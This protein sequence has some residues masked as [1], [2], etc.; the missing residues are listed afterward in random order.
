MR[1]KYKCSGCL[2]SFSG[3]TRSIEAGERV[4]CPS[5]VVAR[6]ADPPESKPTAFEVFL[7]KLLKIEES[8]CGC[9]KGTAGTASLEQSCRICRGEE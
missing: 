7:R 3:V 5:C 2:A 4:Y 1:R 8:D 9:F 6:S